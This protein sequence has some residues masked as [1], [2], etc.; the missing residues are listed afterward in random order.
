[1]TRNEAPR[2]RSGP[3]RRGRCRIP[4]RR[5]S[6]NEQITASA[7]RSSRA[8]RPSSIPLV[9]NARSA[10]FH[11]RRQVGPSPDGSAVHACQCRRRIGRHRS[12]AA[13][14][15]HTVSC[16]I[17]ARIGDPDGPVVIVRGRE[18]WALRMLIAAGKRGCTPIVT[19]GPRWSGYV[20]DL[21]KFGIAIETVRER[22]GAP[23]AGEHARYVLRSPV[24]V[25]DQTEGTWASP[26]KSSVVGRKPEG[27]PS[28]QRPQ[29]LTSGLC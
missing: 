2:S 24:F 16:T 26:S 7:T 27:A 1:M 10:A 20:H 19:P 17:H 29:K 18:A 5:K 25:V 6:N 23:F 4:Q 3:P 12:G 21:R 15:T 28:S 11:H 14:M 13:T 8:F 22:H 9:G